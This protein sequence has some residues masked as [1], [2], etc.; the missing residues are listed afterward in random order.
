MRIV[1]LGPFGLRPK[2]TMTRRALPLARAL[3]ARGHAVRVILPPW[4]CP[5]DSGRTWQQ[6]G[7][8]VVNV[9]LPLLLPLLGH[10]A[11]AARLLHSAL[12]FHPDVIHCF[13]PKA[14]AGLVAAAVWSMQR[15]RLWRGR[16]IVDADDWEGWG[17]WNE[18]SST[19]WAQRRFFAWQEQWGL[20]HCD[21]VTVA[22]RWLQRRVEE[23]REE[24]DGVWYVPNGT[25][26][27]ARS[28]V[29]EGIRKFIGSKAQRF[30]SSKWTTHG[31]PGTLNLEPSNLQPV[32]LY[33]RFVEFEVRQVV[34]IWQRV[35]E[36]VPAARLL[37]VGKGLRGEER[38]LARQA[39]AEGLEETMDI[40]GWA[41]AEELPHLLA[42]A[43]V[44]MMPVEDTVL[45]RAKCPVRLLDLMAAG[46]PVVAHAVG[47]YAELVEDGV[48]GLLVP[49][50]EQAAFVAAVIRL[51]E[52]DSLREAMAK[53]GQRRVR[54]AF[55]WAHL[56]QRV[57][58]AYGE[59]TTR[60]G[61]GATHQPPIS[62]LLQWVPPLAWMGLIFF[63]SSQSR[64]PSH[65]QL[66]IARLMQTGG[67]M[68]AFGMLWALLW[69]AMMKTWPSGRVVWWAFLVSLLYAGSDEY[70]QTFV[71]GRHGTVVD[72]GV[73]ILG[74]LVAWGLIV[75]RQRSGDPPS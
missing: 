75:W 52:D 23:M 8:E 24:S 13:K 60:P 56:V 71:P 43:D 39:T 6:K 70:H 30:E 51:L 59:V 48:S 19:S 47:E 7:V 31:P 41:D 62:N 53:A 58:R 38:A 35:V 54:A 12:R 42:S 1:L 67:H 44:A 20:R 73:D 65:P 27:D 34:D 26:Q 37:V 57:E 55:G 5:E 18:I 15:L 22:S 32:L 36:A 9:R 14:Y 50:G 33:T 49:A 3:A 17:G 45:A 4:D 11:L 72:L 29:R 28:K 16:L 61:S 68:F 66:T 46:V 25:E 40:T 64:L 74:M 69:R 10:L 21:G 2:M 63:L